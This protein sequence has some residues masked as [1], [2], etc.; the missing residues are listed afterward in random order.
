[1]S[2]P[3]GHQRLRLRVITHLPQ[4]LID[5]PFE[6]LMAAV[7]GIAGVAQVTGFT[8]SSAVYEILPRW[9]G[10]AWG[11]GLTIGAATVLVGL[12][13]RE[14]GT[15]VPVGL[16]TLALACA[17]YSLAII[18]TAGWVPTLPASALIL[19]IA[20]ICGFRA[21]ILTSQRVVLTETLRVADLE[22]T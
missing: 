14:Y 9:G 13:R 20:L 21:F 7:A 2:D 17:A 8:S 15:T 19:A 4:A 10:L 5:Y 3:A 11:L 6:V 12:Y 18:T 16:R 1:M 22:E